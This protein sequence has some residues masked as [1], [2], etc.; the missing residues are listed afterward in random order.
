MKASVS[1]KGSLAMRVIRAKPT[2]RQR[3][4]DALAAFLRRIGY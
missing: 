2:R 3:V 1:M 4:A